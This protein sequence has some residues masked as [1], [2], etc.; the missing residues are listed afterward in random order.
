MMLKNSL[1]P[2]IDKRPL[3]IGKNKKVPGLFKDELGG[4]ITTEFVALTAKA[5]SYLD[6]D[7]NKHKK[8]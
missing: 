3:L 6:D 2:L 4:K 8:S 5:Y 7:G 1:L